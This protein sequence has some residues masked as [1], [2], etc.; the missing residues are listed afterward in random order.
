MGEK[1]LLGSPGRGRALLCAL[2]ASLNYF[3]GF[4]FTFQNGKYYLAYTIA[5]MAFWNNFDMLYYVWTLALKA[6]VNSHSME[7]GGLFE[8][9]LE[10]FMT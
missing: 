9:P 7:L 3:M 6:L 8:S 4:N 2:C 1:G 5:I 10:L